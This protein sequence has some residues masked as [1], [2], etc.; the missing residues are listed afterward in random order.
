MITVGVDKV[1]VNYEFVDDSYDRAGNTNIGI[2][3]M[4]TAYARIKLYSI[5]DEI[6]SSS[7][8]R[9]LYYDTDSVIFV[10]KKGSGWKVPEIGDFLGDMT[11][12]IDKDYG[13]EAFINRFACGGPK[14]YAY[15][16]KTPT[17]EKMVTKIKGLNIT[18]GLK[19]ELNFDVVRDYAVK[20][21]TGDVN[22][23]KTVDQ[24]QFRTTNK[25]QIFTSLFSKKYR[26]VLDKRIV[27]KK[28]PLQ[29]VPF[30]YD[31]KMIKQL[32]K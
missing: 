23:F 32:Q 13:P 14:N 8:G 15:V 5:I 25:H 20:Y 28:G 21:R 7:Q 12:E 31:Y 30:G 18:S 9:V 19:E 29:T 6:E 16:V 10:D 11:D 3:A 4:V 1:L 2:A 22:A 24:L 17:M 26:A 27:L